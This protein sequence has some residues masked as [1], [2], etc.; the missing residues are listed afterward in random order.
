MSLGA[1]R[2]EL[3]T[4][5]YVSHVSKGATRWTFDVLWKPSRD[6]RYR[7]NTADQQPTVKPSTRDGTH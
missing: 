1:S 7:H 3:G 5:L 6:A 2:V 4:V